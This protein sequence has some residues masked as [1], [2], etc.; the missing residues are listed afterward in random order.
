MQNRAMLSS[1]TTFV[2][3]LYSVILAQYA[4]VWTLTTLISIALPSLQN[5]M[6]ILYLGLAAIWVV[7]TIITGGKYMKSSPLSWLLIIICT[8][9]YILTINFSSYKTSI[10]FRTFTC[11]VLLALLFTQVN[12]NAKTFL[13]TSMIM[14][15][16]GLPYIS[17][18]VANVAQNEQLNMGTSYAFLLPAVSTIVYFQKY[19]WQDMG[20]KKF[21]MYVLV[22]VNLFYILV[23]LF[24]GSRGVVLSIFLTVLFMYLIPYDDIKRGVRFKSAR[25]VIFLIGAIIILNFFWE[26]LEWIS[27]RG[28][29][30]YALDRTIEYHKVGDAFTGR[31][32]ILEIAWAGIREHPFVGHGL[33]TFSSYT[34]EMVPYIHNSIIQLLFD[35][36]V[37]LLM[38][39]IYPLFVSMKH[40]INRCSF[41]DYSLIIT[42]FS[43]SVPSS[44]FSHDVWGSPILWIYVGYSLL[45]YRK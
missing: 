25:S 11:E 26:I 42:L 9:S 8:V 29:S 40:W 13:I 33:A 1:K 16:M 5:V 30:F 14:P 20:F 39:V 21:L 27:G 24:S 15:L 19:I 45:F 12:I 44:F 36:G 6:A 22:I 28:I 7:V 2:T 23:I 3:Q 32:N 10:I 17:T 43:A 35:G 18:L 31:D 4:G 38:S 41:N 37:V 34:N